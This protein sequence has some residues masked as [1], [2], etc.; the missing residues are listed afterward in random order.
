MLDRL[1]YTL[2]EAQEILQTSRAG[3][4]QLERAGL[5]VMHGENHGKRVTGASL[6]TL[7][8]RIAEGEDIWAVVKRGENPAP[9][10]PKRTARGR[11]TKTREDDGGTSPRQKMGTDSLASAPLQSKEQDWLKRI[12]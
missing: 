1:Y 7:E 10:E 12:I 2:N 4:K 9:S 5:I 8:V 6:R 3:L 11:S